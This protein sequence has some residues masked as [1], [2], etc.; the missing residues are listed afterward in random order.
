MVETQSKSVVI[1]GDRTFFSSKGAV[2]RFKRDLKNEDNEKLAKNDYFKDNWTY[3]FISNE[4]NEIKVKLV[5]KKDVQSKNQ[6]KALDSDEKRQMLKLKLKQMRDN[7]C[8]QSQIK[9]K[10]KMKG[11]VPDDLAALYLEI[12]KNKINV[13]IPEPS[14]VLEKPDEYKNVIFTMIQSFGLFKG[15]NNP[16]VNYYRLLAK[17]LGIPTTY[18]PQQQQQQQQQQQTVKDSINQ[19][20]FIEKLRIERENNINIEVDE[21]MKKIY[22]SLGITTGNK[23]NQSIEL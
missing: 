5:N 18:V 2:D 9:M 13:P 20:S 1:E 19:D 10:M 21:E 12:K 3:E 14:E 22:E 8:S 6:P 23:E 17:H 4:N 15:Q 7:R 16:L 11:D